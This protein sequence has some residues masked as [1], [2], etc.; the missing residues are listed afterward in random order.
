MQNFIFILRYN[1]LLQWPVG[2][3]PE[4]NKS[5]HPFHEPPSARP[6]AY[7]QIHS[8]PSV[9]TKVSIALLEISE[10]GSGGEGERFE[11]G[12]STAESRSFCSYIRRALIS[13]SEGCSRTVTTLH[14]TRS[15]TAKRA[16]RRL[17]TVLQGVPLRYACPVSD[18]TSNLFDINRSRSPTGLLSLYL[19]ECTDQKREWKPDEHDNV[20]L[21]AAAMNVRS[22]FYD[23]NTGKGSRS[24]K[25]HSKED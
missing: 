6:L 1:T 24:E 7:P 22:R 16:V 23:R 9:R 13:K 2:A 3:R 4:L 12:I 25:C 10:G 20:G 8:R 18:R 15:V 19:V 17:W 21:E 5:V 14:Q 11:T